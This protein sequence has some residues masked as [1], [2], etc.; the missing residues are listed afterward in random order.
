MASCCA[1]QSAKGVEMGEKKR[2]HSCLALADALAVLASLGHAAQCNQPPHKASPRWKKSEMPGSRC[3]ILRSRA[4]VFSFSFHGPR[5]V[6]M[7]GSN[8]LQRL[9]PEQRYAPALGRGAKGMRHRYFK[10]AEKWVGVDIYARRT[11]TGALAQGIGAV[12]RR[13]RAFGGAG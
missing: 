8:M 5:L 7:Q 6:G 9:C 2:M 10:E 13:E 12:V 11:V 4:R 3:C 1:V